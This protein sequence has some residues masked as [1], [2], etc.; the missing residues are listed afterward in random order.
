MKSSLKTRLILA[1]FSIILIPILVVILSFFIG[2]K[3]LISEDDDQLDQLFT[4]IKQEIRINEDF[5]PNEKQFNK[6]ITPLLNRYD[7]N[8][9]IQTQSGERLF[10]SR[11][12]RS[13]QEDNDFFFNL[14][15]FQVQVQT[16]EGDV[17]N[18]DIIANSYQREPFNI[19]KD[20]INLALI[21]VGVGLFTL[22]VLILVWTR[23]ISRTV[24]FPLRH[25]FEATEEMKEG[26]LDYPINYKRGD[27]IG[28]FIQG[29]NLMRQHLKESSIKQKQYEEA[30]KELIANISHDLRTPLSS[31]KGY[32]EGLQDGI[33]QNEEMK[34]RYLRVIHDKTN[35]LDTLIE[36]LFEFSKM[37]LEQLPI[38]K[39]VVNMADFFLDMLGRFQFDLQIRGVDMTFTKQIP[40]L[41]IG[42]DPTRIEQVMSNLIDNAVRYGGDRITIEVEVDQ[43]KGSL[44]VIVKDNGQGMDEKDL[45]NIFN[46]FYRGEKSRSTKHGG[47]GLGLSIVQ[48]IVQA[49]GGEIKAESEKGKGS[50]FILTIANTIS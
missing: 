43:V 41:N 10:D 4:D 40:P 31:I 8:L 46:P 49:H 19:F 18:A 24:L 13:V 5:L 37:E 3:N 39:D 33:V 27:E 23:Y 28:R 35:H 6:K 32:V 48:Y 36:D 42:L 11:N 14:N 45:T 38:E 47:S 30:R 29:F 2:S 26:N 21:S 17:W 1:F 12:F 25:I 7:I 44:S 16:S 9:T 34:M 22:I 15:N 20:I 50:L